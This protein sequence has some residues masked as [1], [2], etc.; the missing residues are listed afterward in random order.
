M[1]L[2][3]GQDL[4][5]AV[6]QLVRQGHDVAS[7]SLIVEENIRMGRGHRGMREGAGRLTRA[8]RR[9][10]PTFLEEASADLGQ[11]G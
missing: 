8:H 11:C 5:D 2:A 1:T 3:A 10:D 9:V 6:A 4:M 7:T